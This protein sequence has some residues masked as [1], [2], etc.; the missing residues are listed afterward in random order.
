MNTLRLRFAGLL[1]GFAALPAFSQV[2]STD[3]A[4]PA[5]PP[6]VGGP[7]IALETNQG[8]IV[9]ELYPDKAP[10]SVANFLSYARDGHYNGTVFHRIIGDLLVQGGAYTPDL[11]RKPDRAPIPNESKNGLS[12]LRGTI[13]AARRPGDNNSATSQFFI[14]TVDNRQF[15][16]RGDDAASSGYCVFGRVIEGLDVLDKIRA[17]PT[18]ARAPFAADVP[19]SPVVIERVQILQE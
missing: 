19:K 18:G 16:H 11:Q 10:R 9:L 5:P 15:D 14:N 4:V 7:R 2:R 13:A 17:L 1:L 12:N 3:L 8:R 6:A